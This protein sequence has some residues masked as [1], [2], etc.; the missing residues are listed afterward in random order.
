MPVCDGTITL[1]VANSDKLGK[2]DRK[3]TQCQPLLRESSN[4]GLSDKGIILV[5]RGIETMSIQQRHGNLPCV[6]LA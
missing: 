4:V 2:E 6:T 1:V 5:N 3:R